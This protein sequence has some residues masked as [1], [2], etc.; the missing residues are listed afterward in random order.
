MD[1][2][3]LLNRFGQLQTHVNSDTISVSSETSSV[4]SPSRAGKKKRH[5]KSKASRSN[6]SAATLSDSTIPAVP[7]NGV[8]TSTD[9]GIP[10]RQYPELSSIYLIPRGFENRRNCC[11]LNVSL[12]TLLHT[13]PFIDSFRALQNQRYFLP[14]VDGTD[15]LTFKQDALCRVMLDVIHQYALTS[16]HEKT[17]RGSSKCD[18]MD[19]Y[20]SATKQSRNPVSLDG[21]RQAICSFNLGSPIVPDER[22]ARILNL[23]GGMQEDGA[24]CLNRI[25]SRFHEEIGELNSKTSSSATQDHDGCEQEDPDDWIVTDRSGKRRPQARQIQLQGGHSQISDLFSGV[26]IT[27]SAMKHTQPPTK[28]LS[29]DEMTRQA[30]LFSTK[31]PFFILPLEIDDQKVTSIETALTRLTEAE[32]VSDYEDKTVGITSQLNRR[33]AIDR[34]PPYLILQLKRFACVP[35]DVSLTNGHSGQSWTVQKSLKLITVQ[36]EFVVP[37]KLLSDE[38]TF[39]F[40]QRRYRLHAVIFHVGQSAASGHYTVAIRWGDRSLNRSANDAPPSFLYLDDTR[41]CCL[42]GVDAIKSLLS[43]HRP[44]NATTLEFGVVPRDGPTA[45]HSDISQQPRTPYLLVY[46]ACVLASNHRTG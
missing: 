1:L 16:P 2:S 18:S 32:R 38:N 12:Q 21:F 20:S 24:E 19:P 30:K 27:R 42:Q 8:S 37:R 17:K 34:L 7:F 14:P 29:V 22:F 45:V 6:R 23:T 31:E 40:D 33:L 26:L 46:E 41:A 43:T 25:L 3:E 4:L 10:S 39:T 35:L 36:S 13:P 15:Q 44:L 11:Y 28:G 9:S 5:R